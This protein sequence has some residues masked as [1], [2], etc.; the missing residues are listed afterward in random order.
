MMILLK[1]FALF[2]NASGL[3]L[4]K[5]KSEA[6]FGGVKEEL[7]TDILSVTSFSEGRFPF[8]YLGMPIQTK[9]LQKVDC[10]CL[11][12]RICNRIHNS[13]ARH[14]YDAGRL[15]LIKS[16]FTTLHSYWAS[17][18]IIPKAVINRIK[19]VCRNYL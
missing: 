5:S 9:R 16:F 11:V 13:G 7:K 19:A 12:E 2:S 17:I 14:L 15:V 3:M 6:F 1:S 10:E 4:N 8:K 18:F